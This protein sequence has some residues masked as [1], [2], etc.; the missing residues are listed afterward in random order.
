[1]SRSLTGCQV[2]DPTA[3]PSE[4]KCVP[5]AARLE[6][7][8]GRA[9]AEGDR[10]P[11]NVDVYG[12]NGKVGTHNVR[13]LPPPG[14]LVGRKGT[15][16]AVQYSDRPFWPIDTVYYVRPTSTEDDLRYIYY[17]LQYLPLRL[18][19]AA[20]GVPGLSRRDAYALRG[21]FPPKPEQAAIARLLD[22]V[23]DAIDRVHAAQEQAVVVKRALVQRLLSM[24]TGG[25]PT[26]KTVIGPVPRSWDVVSL[27]TVV[28]DF[29]YG[30]SVAMQT[31]GSLPILRMGNI[32]QGDVNFGGLKYV[33]LP[34]RLTD[35]YL[36]RR[37]DVLFNRT[38]SQ[39]HVGKIGIYRDD[40]AAVFASY[41]IRLHPDEVMVDPYFLGQVLSSY[42][43]Q[44]RIKRY[45]TP[46]VQQ[47]NIN[48]TNLGSV[49]VPIPKGGAG[50]G[51]Q[52]AIASTLERADES[53]RSSGPALEALNS[54]K[55]SLMH[56]LLNARVRL[57][58]LQ[59][60]GQ[61]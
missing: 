11:G 13:W 49:L 12:S 31:K 50:L 37:G 61:S 1:M 33:S 38:N 28:S 4:W 3:V 59:V 5:L 17:L 8:Y 44:C 60:S 15:V 47:V 48:A 25:E 34:D 23:C 56:L 14:V 21:V 32:Q 39:E 6:L 24:G 16:G 42:A 43:T 55:R 19:N 57:Q 52:R 35:R 51:E 58:P 22:D 18:L 20:T 7:L 46:G 27:R 53:I 30:L 2:F 54:L 9:L 45:A 36:L 29:Q 41:L 10:R 26:K 40:R